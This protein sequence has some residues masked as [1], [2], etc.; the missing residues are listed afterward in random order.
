MAT[1]VTCY[2]PTEISAA[3]EFPISRKMYFADAEEYNEIVS[4]MKDSISLLRFLLCG[5]RKRKPAERL[6][7]E[8][9]PHSE[10]EMKLH[11]PGALLFASCH[12][13]LA[14]LVRVEAEKRHET[15]SQFAERALAKE[16]GVKPEAMEFYTKTFEGICPYCGASEQVG[17]IC[18][19]CGLDLRGQ[20]PIR[21]GDR[22]ITPKPLPE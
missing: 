4:E 6:E 20:E 11:L 14:N 13:Q 10:A 2:G 21:V 17:F 5:E 9:Y 7:I 19:R 15:I 16:A 22:Y 12:T 1:I 18:E 3:P 8:E